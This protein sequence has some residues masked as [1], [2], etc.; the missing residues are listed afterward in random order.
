MHRVRMS[1]P[2]FRQF[3]W[4]AE[5][6]AVNEKYVEGFRDPL[7]LETVPEE[8]VLHKTK[9]FSAQATR[10]FGLG[11]LSLRSFWHILRKGNAVLKSKPF[12]L[13]YFSTTAFHVCWL[14]R[15]WKKKFNIPFVIDLQDP[16]RNDYYND[17]PKHLRP[18]KHALFY[19]LHKY[20]E[21]ATMPMVDGLISVSNGYLQMMED[22]YGL[23]TKQVPAAMIPFGAAE[24]DFKVSDQLSPESVLLKLNTNTI[25]VVYMGAVTSFF[26]PIIEAFF[27]AYL[28]AADG[29]KKHHFYFIGTSYAASGE[30]KVKALAINVGMGEFVTEQTDRLPYFQALGIL[31]KA[32]ILFIPGSMDVDYNA[33]KVYNNILSGRPI[34]SIFHKQSEVK[35]I[36]EATGAGLVVPLD[37]NENPGELEKKIQLKMKD[38]FGL[39]KRTLQFN[40]SA[41]NN[42]LAPQRTKEQ[43]HLFEQAISYFKNKN[44]A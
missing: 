32:D 14:G 5:V 27:R 22:R 6:I 35:S 12:D 11:S 25:N 39:E 1:L 43:I 9:A 7:L 24:L 31:K 41:I 38:F 10:K 36:I 15:Y 40:D 44:R 33:S 20:L 16:W 23:L 42:F 28:R 3:G 2:Y 21:A 34:F 13:V 26:L 18:P 37:G 17:K 4:E 19:Q 30:Q 29:E 8:I